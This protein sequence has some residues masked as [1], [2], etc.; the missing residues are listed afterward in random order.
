MNHRE[1]RRDV[2][3]ARGARTVTQQPGGAGTEDNRDG[4]CRPNPKE[5]AAKIKANPRHRSQSQCRFKIRPREQEAAQ[6][7]KDGDAPAAHG[8]RP[9]FYGGIWEYLLRDVAEHDNGDR[10]RA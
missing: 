1:M 10:S 7:E 9:V 4:V 2:A 8:P 5:A 6:D 3:Q